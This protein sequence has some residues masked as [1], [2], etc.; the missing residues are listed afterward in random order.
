[1]RLNFIYLTLILFTFASC[2]KNNAVVESFEKPTNSVKSIETRYYKPIFLN[3]K[4]IT[5]QEINDLRTCAKIE[6]FDE[7]NNVLLEKELR[8]TI[9][10]K[11]S[12]FYTRTFYF[13]SS[14]GKISK[15]IKLREESVNKYGIRLY[16]RDSLGRLVSITDNGET[17]VV[18]WDDY[19]PESIS[20]DS[21]N[22]KIEIQDKI[23]TITKKIH[24]DNDITVYMKQVINESKH[25]YYMGI[26]G[27]SEYEI[28]TT[29]TKTGNAIMELAEYISYGTVSHKSMTRYKYNNNGSM[30]E[31]EIYEIKTP[32]VFGVPNDVP[33]EKQDEYIRE[34]YFGTNVKYET[35][36]KKIELEYDCNDNLIYEHYINKE[37]IPTED[38]PSEFNIRNYWYYIKDDNR[39]SPVDSIKTYYEYVYNS[40]ND[41]IKRVKYQRIKDM[42]P[43]SQ[44]IIGKDKPD[45][46][47]EEIVI[48]K[49]EY[50]N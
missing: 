37:N 23:K 7:F 1:M 3:D 14:T 33:F 50:F 27:L 34:N 12:N 36:Y 17:D 48:R 24:S 22:N 28:T 25:D 4:W 49:I 42:N 43:F 46:Q 30:I 8:D 44:S 32:I 6:Y 35:C 19:L 2:D 26:Y 10:K 39:I 16:N 38:F 45:Q 13:D 5:G 15:E 41:W 11:Y 9:N 47:V 21:E 20:Y 31:K 18:W 40:K 29:D